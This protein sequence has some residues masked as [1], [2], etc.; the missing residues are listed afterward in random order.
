MAD[1]WMRWVD[2]SKLRDLLALIVAQPDGFTPTA[3][4]RV[5][6]SSGTFVLPSGEPFGPSN[7]YHHRRALEKLELVV[8][9]DGRLISNLNAVECGPMLTNLKTKKLDDD[10]RYVFGNRVV[11]NADCYETFWK[12]FMPSKRPCSLQE[13]TNSGVPIVLKLT[14]SGR[15]PQ[16][17][18]RLSLRSQEDIDLTEVHQGYKAIQAIHF[19]MRAW[20]VHQLKF[21]DEMYRVGEGYRI[22]PVEIRPEVEVATI[23]NALIESLEFSGDWASPRVGDLLFSVASRLRVPLK[24]VKCVLSE[25]LRV[26]AGL[27]SPIAVSDRMILA[28]QS[29]QMRK[30]ILKGFLALPSGEHVSHI[31]VHHE[32][33]NRIKRTSGKELSNVP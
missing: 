14:K 32:L 17:E 5:A 4:D 27:I 9:H 23:K 18:Y 25:W 13:F 8:R 15:R 3:L 11:R 7:R 16:C 26:H 24:R 29:K 10:Q 20:G 28:G 33:A 2:F 1:Y 6:I 12:T 30:L 21:L 31:Q 19:G 22:F